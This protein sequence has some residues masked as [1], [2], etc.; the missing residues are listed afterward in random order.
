MALKV[1][2]MGGRRS[3][4]TSALSSI[5]HEMTHGETKKFLTVTDLTVLET[6]KN[7][8]T[9]EME[10]QDSLKGKRMELQDAIKNGGNKEFLVDK[11]PTSHFWDYKMKVQIPGTQRSMEII[12]RDSAGEFFHAGMA[13]HADTMRFV[14]ESDVFV[15]VVDTPYLMSSDEVIPEAA[16]VAGDIQTFLTNMNLAAH[17]YMQVIFVPIKCEKWVK[18]GTI[19][20]VVEKIKKVYD[21]TLTNIQAFPNIE[22]SIIPI[23]T[24]GDIV[25]SQLRAPYS[26]YDTATNT[27]R[28]CAKV[29]EIQ[30]MF[31][32]GT[33]HQKEPHEI[34]QEDMENT[35]AGVD[36]L[37]PHC[38]FKLHNPGKATFSPHNC[39]QLPLHIIRF[40]FKKM[41]KVAKGGF[42]GKF[43][44]IL[45]GSI[46]KEDLQS[47]L[48]NIQK[49]N[50]IKDEGEGITIIRS[51]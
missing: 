22:I 45:F 46:R 7:P 30:V 24:A 26:I 25:F 48:N 50:L 8:I 38:W 12:F 15:I 40:M 4:K 36:I 51:L 20:D 37:R 13:H 43:G 31:P 47:A 35:F 27:K 32:D 41:E 17:P 6:K 5:F 21:T 11:S 44:E 3:G 28:K 18:D 16:N 39:E 1:L 14:S 23:Q 10:T 33:F 2:M 49:N 34:I 42:W 29:S 9:E 19:G